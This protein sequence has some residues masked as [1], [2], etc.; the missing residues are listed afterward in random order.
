MFMMDGLVFGVLLGPDN[1]EVYGD[2]TDGSQRNR[3][4]LHRN[5]LGDRLLFKDQRGKSLTSAQ[6][7][8]NTL[9]NQTRITIERS[10]AHLKQGPT[11]VPSSYFEQRTN[12]IAIGLKAIAYNLFRASKIL[13]D[14]PLEQESCA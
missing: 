12:Q 7:L 11:M 9:W 8:M 10:F 3:C 13:Q 2:K 4:L 14:L 1:G 6:R 5:G